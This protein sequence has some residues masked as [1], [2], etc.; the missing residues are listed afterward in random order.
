MRE[1]VDRAKAMGRH[2]S[3]R[4][5]ADAAGPSPASWRTGRAT[6][7][8]V[9]LM[10]LAMSVGAVVVLAGHRKLGSLLGS[11]RASASVASTP[12]SPTRVLGL[13][14]GRIAYGTKALTVT[15][16]APVAAGSPP[17]T[18]RPAVAGTWA[19]DGNSVVF[20]P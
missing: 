15:L 1:H 20:T 17:P 18:L 12:L 8:T 13:P 2:L 9:L 16:S 4:G 7:V 10:V 5:P 3:G 19:E 14:P 11:T 6:S